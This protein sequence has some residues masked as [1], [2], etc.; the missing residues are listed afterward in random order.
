MANVG[1]RESELQVSARML[2]ALA[3][4]I[5]GD[6]SVITN[7]LAYIATVVDPAEVE[8]S[9]ARC[10]TISAGLAHLGALASCADTKVSLALGHILKIFG[11]S[12][13]LD[14]A[15]SA[16]KVAVSQGLIELA[17]LLLRELIG[18]SECCLD[19]RMHAEAMAI[20]IK[21]HAKSD[22]EQCYESLGAFAG[23]ELGERFVVEAGIVDLIFRDHGWEVAVVCEDHRTTV[24]LNIA[25]V[26]R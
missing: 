19:D 10:H 11:L 8:R 26:Y 15:K 17:A 2:R 21:A 5:R 1:D 12:A 18:D 23:V 4:R 9:R 6:L 16:E 13:G 24:R 25:S 14:P 20:V 7:D 3:H 22:F